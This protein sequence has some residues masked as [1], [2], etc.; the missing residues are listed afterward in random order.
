MSER[1]SA[2]MRV[3]I[4]TY[5]F[6]LLGILV[7]LMYFPPANIHCAGTSA[8]QMINRSGVFQLWRCFGPLH[9]KVLAGSRGASSS[10]TPHTRI[11]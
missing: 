9:G 11:K 5:S 8:V 7:T 3:T 4:R 10:E 2:F 6:V 1:V